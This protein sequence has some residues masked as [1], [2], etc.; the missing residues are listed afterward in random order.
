[1]KDYFGLSRH[2]T[3]EI[4]DAAGEESLHLWDQLRISLHL[5]FCPRCAEEAQKLELLREVMK[6]DF[7]PPCE[8]FSES[9]MAQISA[10]EENIP[11]IQGS[12]S[13]TP[14]GFSIRS[15]IITGC[16]LVLSLGTVFL[17]L[18]FIHV[19]DDQGSSFM[20]P[21]GLTIGSILTGYTAL[22][23]GSHLKELSS[24]FRLR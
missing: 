3:E 7:F 9:I 18:D 24:R 22:F 5:F 13:S 20:L 19:A 4:F 11:G 1:M 16:F 17:G 8:G 21:I 15:W 6:T 12:F 10:E 23:I 2:V 14:G